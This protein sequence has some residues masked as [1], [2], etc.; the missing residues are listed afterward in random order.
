MIN[1]NP[2]RLA[3]CAPKTEIFR[4][5]AARVFATSSI[6]E[7]ATREDYVSTDLFE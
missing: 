7:S 2:L 6:T 5:S 4:I 3:Y 1:K